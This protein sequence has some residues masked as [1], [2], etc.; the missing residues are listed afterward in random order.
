MILPQHLDGLQ[1]VTREICLIAQCRR[2]PPGFRTLLP[3]I[4]GGEDEPPS[5]F[6]SVFQ[7]QRAGKPLF[8]GQC[9]C[10]YCGGFNKCKEKGSL[11]RVE[12]KIG[13][14]PKLISSEFRSEFRS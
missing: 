11:I 3:P 9:A 7:W 8:I 10:V 4:V 14:P 6:S 5:I 2:Y 1:V 12:Y 13:F